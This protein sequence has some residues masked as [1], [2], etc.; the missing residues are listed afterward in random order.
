VSVL[1]HYINDALCGWCYGAAPLV[2]AA[3]HVEGLDI[4][5]HTGGLWPQPTRLPD[6]MRQYIRQADGRV[7]AMSGQPYG[8]AYLDGLLFD[9]E[10]ILE[11]RTPTAA[12][13]AA[14]SLDEAKALPMLRAIQRGHY[15][16]GLHV[17]RPEVLADLAE[18]IGLDRDAFEQASENVDVDSH[19]KATRQLM[20]QI[21]ARGYPAFVL[22]TRARTVSPPGYR[23]KSQRQPRLIHAIRRL[24]CPARRRTACVCF[25]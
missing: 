14:A 20:A 15:V 4:Q 11:S 7:A 13:L 21:G 3:E 25:P 5:L 23:N 16:D 2:S 18:S 8:P 6:E 22:E 10:L 17:V 9:P 24:G 1:L 19:I 12:V